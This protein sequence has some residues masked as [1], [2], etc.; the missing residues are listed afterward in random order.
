MQL[1][2]L[3]LGLFTLLSS[4]L[5]HIWVVKVEYLVGAQ[6]WP[7]AALLGI[8]LIF[9]SLWVDDI[10]FS[11]MIGIFGFIVLYGARE[12]VKQR[13]RVEKGWFPRKPGRDQ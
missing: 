12:L 7:L 3:I 8:I 2:G 6:V 11:G 5:G 9:S 13:E 4:A 10:I 1:A